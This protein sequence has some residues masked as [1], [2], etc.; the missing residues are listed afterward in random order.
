MNE[1]ELDSEL[2]QYEVPEETVEV[3]VNW[4]LEFLYPDPECFNENC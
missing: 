1:D 4:E 2:V 3:L